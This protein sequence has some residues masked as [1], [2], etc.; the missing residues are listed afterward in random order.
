MKLIRLYLSLC[1]FSGI[2]FHSYGQSLAGTW[3][4]GTA[5]VSSGLA[6]HYTFKA[7][8]TF[9]YTVNSDDALQRIISIGGTYTYKAGSGYVTLLVKYT[10]E[11]IGGVIDR[12]HIT[13]SN[14]AWSIEKGKVQRIPIA[15]PLYQLLEL[16]FVSPNVV[17]IEQEDKFHKVR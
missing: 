1:L 4:I 3:Q 7:N 16:K 10:I 11:I 2:A 9:E 15:K 17:M 8:K 12:S 6:A 5:Q 13:T 14:N